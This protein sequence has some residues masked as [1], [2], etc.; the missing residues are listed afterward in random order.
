[1]STKQETAL[2]AGG[3]FWGMQDLIRRHPGVTTTRV[4]YTGG[5]VPNPTYEDLKTGKSG[6]AESIQIQFD[7]AETSY[8]DILA[9]FFQIHDPTTAPE[10]GASKTCSEHGGGGVNFSPAS[11]VFVN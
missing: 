4:G 3:C 2:L 6:H 11:S 5:T 8:R 7:P 10:L 1:M 9:L